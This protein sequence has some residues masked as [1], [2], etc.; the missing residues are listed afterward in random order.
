MDNQLQ[1]ARAPPAAADEL[2]HLMPTARGSPS[3]RDLRRPDLCAVHHVG[4]GG[5]KQ[6]FKVAPRGHRI[7]SPLCPP[8][9]IPTHRHVQVAQ[10]VKS[11][12][13]HG[14]ETRGSLTALERETAAPQSSGLANLVFPQSS[15][16][17]PGCFSIA[18]R[19]DQFCPPQ[20]IL[21]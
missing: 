16:I 21:R 8:P 18:T 2:I 10:P 9:S 3:V 5:I 14:H 12:E 15:A 17:Q 7:R 6:A 20:K 4:F 19:D 11:V 1:T 13:Q